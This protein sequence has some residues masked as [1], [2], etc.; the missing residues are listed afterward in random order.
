[1]RNITGLSSYT[2]TCPFPLCQATHPENLLCLDICCCRR[3]S[4]SIR[5]QAG[6]WQAAGKTPGLA[7][8]SKDTEVWAALSQPGVYISQKQSHAFPFL[9]V[10]FRAAARGSC[11]P[12][13]SDSCRKSQA[14]HLRVLHPPL[15]STGIPVMPFLRFPEGGRGRERETV[16]SP[17]PSG[18]M[19]VTAAGNLCCSLTR[20]VTSIFTAWFP[21]RSLEKA[22]ESQPSPR[23][24]Y[25]LALHALPFVLKQQ[26][27]HTSP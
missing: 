5:E 13:M 21:C 26:G 17:L 10:A 27:K 8:T 23:A 19:L 1:M 24:G 18:L 2:P 16:R 20:T 15:P 25:T 4:T 3:V 12:G 7:S 6:W 22:E 9:W 11:L 14:G